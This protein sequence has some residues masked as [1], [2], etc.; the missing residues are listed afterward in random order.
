MFCNIPDIADGFTHHLWQPFHQKP[1]IKTRC[2]P[3]QR[4]WGRVFQKTGIITELSVL[5]FAFFFLAATLDSLWTKGNGRW[6]KSWAGLQSHRPEGEVVL[7]DGSCVQLSPAAWAGFNICS[8]HTRGTRCRKA[9]HFLRQTTAHP[10]M[11]TVA[12]FFKCCKMCTYLCVVWC[13]NLIWK[14]TCVY[15]FWS[16]CTPLRSVQLDEASTKSRLNWREGRCWAA[17]GMHH[18]MP[19]GFISIVQDGHNQLP[20]PWHSQHGAQTDRQWNLWFALSV[21]CRQL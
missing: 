20:Q 5:T 18:S 16:L 4:G 12:A 9:W 19:H 10:S 17:S 8:C 7:F 13:K 15:S 14:L 11:L 2:Q 6:M 1:Y 21:G 3:G